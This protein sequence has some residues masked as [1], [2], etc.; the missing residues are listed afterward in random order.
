MFTE[1]PAVLPDCPKRDAA[2]ETTPMTPET[3]TL[4][5]AAGTVVALGGMIVGLFAWLRSDMKSLRGEMLG[6]RDELKGDIMAE[7]RLGSKSGH[8][9][10]ARIGLEASA[11]RGSKASST[12]WKASSPGETNRQPPRRNSAVRGH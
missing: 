9:R 1:A 2:G 7:G 6:V 11:W 12:S 4:I 8:S 10:R 5:A 3:T